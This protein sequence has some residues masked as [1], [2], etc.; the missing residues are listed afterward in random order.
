M[1]FPAWIFQMAAISNY[2]RFKKKSTNLNF[3]MKTDKPFQ[4]QNKSQHFYKSKFGHFPDLKE[5]KS[6]LV[7]YT[8][9]AEFGPLVN[10][11]LK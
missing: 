2:F 1:I 5:K 4:L 6:E 9:G 8:G 7:V 10:Y 11:K 3:L